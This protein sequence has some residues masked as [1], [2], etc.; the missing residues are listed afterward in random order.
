[1]IEIILRLID[2]LISLAF[3]VMD[4]ILEHCSLILVLFLL[5]SKLV[6]ILVLLIDLIKLVVSLAQ[7]HYLLEAV[8]FN[9][10]V[11]N[12]DLRDR[13]VFFQSILYPLC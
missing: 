8:W 9:W 11:I 6:D 12:M 5:L 4:L 13:L 10:V 7:S 3:E 1:M 2:G